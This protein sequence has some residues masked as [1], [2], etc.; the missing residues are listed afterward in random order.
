MP[1]RSARLKRPAKSE[2]KEND[3]PETQTRKKRLLEAL[4][5]VKPE[6]I[7][8]EVDSECLEKVGKAHVYVENGDVYDVMLNQNIG[9][10]AFGL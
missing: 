3:D 5:D 9:D 2:S 6:L 10:S 4:K 8:A 1:R 7:H